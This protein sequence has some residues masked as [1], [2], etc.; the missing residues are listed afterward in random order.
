MPLYDFRCHA[1]QATFEERTAADQLA[2]CPECGS[3]DTERLLSPFAGPFTVAPR[4]LAARRSDSARR[5]R[6][7][8]RRE[9]KEER[10]RQREEHGPPPP[11]KP[12]NASGS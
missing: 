7:E 12:P 3:E 6:E 9:R 1:C 10:R 5:V 11:R 8:Q 2:R 4:G